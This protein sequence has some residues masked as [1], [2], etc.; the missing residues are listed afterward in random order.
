MLSD[1]PPVLG[2][3]V[4]HEARVW[5]TVR[6]VDK[7][8][9]HTLHAFV[10]PQYSRCAC[11]AHA[12]EVLEQ[13]VDSR[14]PRPC[15]SAHRVS[16]ATYLA[17]HVATSELRGEYRPALPATTSRLRGSTGRPNCYPIVT[18]STKTAQTSTLI[19]VDP[20]FFTVKWSSRSEGL[21]C[22]T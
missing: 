19:V 9:P 13:L 3:A 16:N 6:I 7:H 11:K 17:G 18:R 15:S 8:V 5:L 22:T 4:A 20:L 2:V 1:T 14:R 12:L 10:N 21:P